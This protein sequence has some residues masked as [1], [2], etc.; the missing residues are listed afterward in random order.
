MR[1]QQRPAPL[2]GTDYWLLCLS[3]LCRAS[4]GL[5]Q[6]EDVLSALSPVLDSADAARM[7]Q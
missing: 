3:W 6:D 4:N 2:I 5:S 1:R 7:L